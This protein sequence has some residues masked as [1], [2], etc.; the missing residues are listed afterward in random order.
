MAPLTS[1]RSLFELRVGSSHTIEILLQIR[2]ADLPWWNSN[3]KDHERELYK[4]IGRRV[5][6]EECRDEIEADRARREVDKH[7][8]KNKAVVVGEA[9]LKKKAK[10]AVKGKGKRGN[11]SMKETKT[12]KQKLSD[13]EAIAENDKNAE[14]TKSV[15]WVMGKSIQICYIMEEIEKSSAAT[16]IFRQKGWEDNSDNATSTTSQGSAEKQSQSSEGVADEEKNVPLATFRSWKKLS[17]RLNLWVFRFD[18]DDPTDL[19]ISGG[20]GFPQ[21]E[22]LPMADIFR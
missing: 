7:F 22:L 20:A 3:L 19:S 10:K 8:N 6:P 18:P 21:P 15:S 5:L 17:K 9:N 14:K 1:T 16:M 2:L 12:K 4:L 11:V 13:K